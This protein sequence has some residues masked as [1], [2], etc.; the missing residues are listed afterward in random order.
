VNRLLWVCQAP[1]IA[2][3]A[4]CSPGTTTTEWTELVATEGQENPIPKAWL[5]DEEARIAHALKLPSGVPKPVPFNFEKARWRAWLPGVPGTAVQYFSHLCANEAGEWVFKTVKDVKG[6]Y[7]ARPQGA[8]SS[9]MLRDPY[10]PEMPWIQRIF[11]LQGDRAHDWGTWFIQPPISN[12]KF[13]E[14]PRRDVRWQA[15]IEEPFVR[16]HGYT[17]KPTLDQNGKPTIYFSDAAPMK[18]DGI[19]QPTATYGYTWRGIV[20]AQDRAN[21]IGGGELIIYDL[22]TKEVLAVRRQ[23]LVTGRNPRGRGD[24]AWEVAASCRMPGANTV[25]LEFKQFAFDVLQTTEPSTTTAN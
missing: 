16:L 3:L 12:Y 24:A 11:V 2:S 1:L 15:S 5:Q 14:Q 6:L 7:F 18:V 9:E 22:R 23:F 17:R 20:R 21:G 8:P 10:G 4:S 19:A 25:G 13:V